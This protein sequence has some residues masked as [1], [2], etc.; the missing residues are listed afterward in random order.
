LCQDFLRTRCRS[1]VLWAMQHSVCV[2]VGMNVWGKT[3]RCIQM[4]FVGSTKLLTYLSWLP[5]SL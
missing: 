4:W 5:S 3:T 2:C 1:C